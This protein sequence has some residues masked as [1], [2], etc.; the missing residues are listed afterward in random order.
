LTDHFGLH[1]NVFVVVKIE[2]LN[3]LSDL[4]K[5]LIDW[6]SLVV[7]LESVDPLNVY[8]L[9]LVSQGLQSLEF[10]QV[11]WSL[12]AAFA[13]LAFLIRLQIEFFQFLIKNQI[14]TLSLI[15]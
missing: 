13:T 12:I 10:L 9:L 5:L 3:L 6:I 15:Y 8:A 14:K 11:N 1:E 7:G 4:V 2:C